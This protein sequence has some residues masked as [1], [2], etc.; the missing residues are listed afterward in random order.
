MKILVLDDEDLAREMLIDAVRGAMPDAEIIDFEDPQKLLLYTKDNACSIAF[1]DINMRGMN[2]IE[3][4]QKLQIIAPTMNIVFVTGYDEYACDALALHASGYL[5]KPVTKEKIAKELSCLRHPVKEEKKEKLL[6]IQCFGNFEVFDS[7]GN[8]VK[9]D[10]LK[11][12]EA[13]AYLVYRRGASCT[14]KEIAAVLFEDEYYD[15]KQRDYM[16]QIISSMVRTL[17]KANA[18]C[19]VVKSY[20]SIAISVEYLDC[21]YYNVN[22]KD[23]KT[24][25]KFTGE[26][27]TQ[28]SWA[29]GVSGYLFQIVSDYF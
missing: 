3:L 4:A 6:K 9:F 8:I 21:D 18:E 25:S 23:K 26:F 27:M 24:L 20:N 22:V 13:F 19:I 15:D 14:V 5:M 2:G 28:Y 29:E 16:Q 12:K 1:L 10:R 17:R 11:A 7:K